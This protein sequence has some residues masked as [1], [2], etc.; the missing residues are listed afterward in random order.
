MTAK[1]NVLGIEFDNLTKRNLI[2]IIINR[3][4]QNDKTFIVTANPE[5]VMYATKNADYKTV[6]ESADYRIAD[7]IGVIYGAKI[8]NQ[9]LAERIPGYELMMELLQYAN[10][11]RKKVYFLGAQQGVIDAL[12][13]KV[14]KQFPKIEVVGAR[15][16]YFDLSDPSVVIDLKEADADFVFLA[17]GYPRQETWISHNIETFNKGVFI[18]VGG[19]F[20][21]LSD[22][23]KRA[24]VIWQKLNLEWFYRL[25]KQPSRWKR[26][27][28]LPLFLVEVII[29]KLKNKGGTS[30]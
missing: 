29:S 3:L 26:T 6:I 4:S 23:V 13:I 9:S 5:I 27:L 2:E 8:L 24:P 14:A 30:I 11:E 28:V 20:D 12:K 10:E 25:L 21:V 7:G 1:V 22:K 15:N 19:S 18:G 17:L 16:G